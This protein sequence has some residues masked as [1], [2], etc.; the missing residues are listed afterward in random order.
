[1]KLI[2][3][4]LL[5]FFLF[6]I[7]IVSCEHPTI[8]DSSN[9]G[10]EDGKANLIVNIATVENVPFPS[11]TTR[12]SVADAFSR[13]SIAVFDSKGQRADVSNKSKDDKDYGSAS[14]FL[15]SGTYQVVVIGHSAKQNPTTTDA[16]KIQFTKATGYSDTFLYSQ[17][18]EVGNK[19]VEVD[20]DLKRIVSLCR[21]VFTDTI[22]KNVTKLHFEYTGGSGYFDASTG[23]G[24]STS[25]TKQQVD[26]DTESGRDSTVYDL[27]TFLPEGVE[28]IH[29]KAVAKDAEDNT[30]CVRELDVPLKRRQI[31]KVSGTFFS[32]QSGSTIAIVI[33]VDDEWEGETIIN[34]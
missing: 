17:Y 33:K 22:P 3:S 25:G 13:I 34:F 5:L 1:M 32:G 28:S 29:L 27:Y 19:P 31:T 26:F 20:A 16:S 4:P 14:F 12:A 6:A 18:V 23:L 24:L 7:V 11:F 15:P 9:S 8:P 21:V 30:V 10:K 2:K